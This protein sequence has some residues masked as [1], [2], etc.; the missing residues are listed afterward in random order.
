MK[1]QHLMMMA[2][3]R[4]GQH[5]LKDP[6]V[7]QT[8]VDTIDPTMQDTIIE[9]GPGRGVL[10]E[11]L[12]PQCQKLIGVEIDNDLIPVLTEKFRN[13]SHF[14]LIHEDIL[15]FNPILYCDSADSV[16]L[17]G[18][19]S[20]SL[21]DHHR[22]PNR[23]GMRDEKISNVKR[24]G[25]KLVG[26]I[27]YNLTTKLF[28]HIM[29]WEY[30]PSAITF[31]I[32]KEVG[33]K[34]VKKGNKNSPLAVCVDMIGEAKLVLQVPPRAFSP[35]PK[36]DSVVLHVDCSKAKT[37]EVG[38]LESGGFVL[39]GQQKWKF[40][41][42]IHKIFRM[43]RKTIYNNLQSLMTKE[44]AR[45]ILEK[46]GLDPMLRPGH[47]SFEQFVILFQVVKAEEHFNPMEDG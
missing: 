34:M 4:F 43:G 21:Q 14:E 27:P 36:V 35:P 6:T 23:S 47:L 26:N 24:G 8:I 44:E 46:S 37:P 25:Y 19:D 18:G 3:K 40:Y 1:R 20:G 5:F 22:F 33:E 2:K 7:L 13:Y 16:H 15:R 28:E 38:G 17:T 42:F 41:D 30:Q 39:E 12:L 10:T 32:Q 31:L 29:L 11:M 9:I 45:R